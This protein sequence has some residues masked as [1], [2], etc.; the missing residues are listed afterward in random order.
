MDAENRGDVRT[1][2]AI[3]HGLHC[4]L[5]ALRFITR[6]KGSAHTP[7][8]STRQWGAFAVL[9]PLDVF[10]LGEQVPADQKIEHLKFA[11]SVIARMGTN[12]FLLKGWT[13]TLVAALFAFG[14]KEADRV[15]VVIAWVPLVVFSILDSYFLWHERLYRKLHTKV[16]AKPEDQIDF[17]MDV[18]E[19]KA[20][21]TW[22]KALVSKTILC[23]YLPLGLL[24]AILTVYFALFPKQA[25]T[26]IQGPKTITISIQ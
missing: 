6:S 1:G 18:T 16:A 9:D 8:I 20:E 5:A 25:V 21:D 10:A 7:S 26:P 13:V 15:F 11:Q 4:L 14:A 24:L 3:D 19:F 17:S 12:S 23:F 22:R 2:L